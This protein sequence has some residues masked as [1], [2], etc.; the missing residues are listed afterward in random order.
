MPLLMTYAPRLPRAWLHRVCREKYAACGRT[1]IV[2]VL[3][4][5][6]RHCLRRR[7]QVLADAHRVFSAG[8]IALEQR[9]FAVAA[10]AVELARRGV[11]AARFEED[12]LDAG[13]E[14]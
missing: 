6:R 12:Q 8:V 2:G 9:Q 13:G 11:A 4:A 3:R 10:R 7:S 14:R 5:A 1:S